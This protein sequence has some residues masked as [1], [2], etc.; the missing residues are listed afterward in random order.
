MTKETVKPEEQKQE[1]VVAPSTELVASDVLSSDFDGI[2]MG[3]NDFLPTKILLMQGISQA[4]A[5]RKAQIGDLVNNMTGE[6][7]GTAGTK[8]VNLLPF[9]MKKYFAVEKHNG[10]KFV[11]SHTV[12]DTGVKLPNDFELNGVKYR[13]MH[14]YVFF[15][16][17]EAMDIPVSISFRSTSHKEGQKLLNFMSN[18][19]RKKPTPQPP[20][21]NWI[22]LD[23][24]GKKNDQGNFM[25]LV[26]N[27]DRVSTEA[28]RNEC[29]TWV[30]VVKEVKDFGDEGSESSGS[31]APAQPAPN[32]KF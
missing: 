30:P 23:A 32:V 16:M 8:P 21:A 13:N 20:F 22:K 12:E 28:E 1:L 14:T 3:A 15:C 17:T 11:F 26:V 9:A 10:T 2:D 4:V 19:A 24:I 25:V 6:V 31:S 7:V 18:Q 27:P 29:R 5:D